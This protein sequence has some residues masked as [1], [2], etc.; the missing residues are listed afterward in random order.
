VWDLCV[1]D[2]LLKAVDVD[3]SRAELD[4]QARESVANIL[5]LV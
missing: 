4:R 1:A 5:V 2:L 3:Y